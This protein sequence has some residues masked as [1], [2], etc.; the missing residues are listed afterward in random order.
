MGLDR[1]DARGLPRLSRALVDARRRERLA[2]GAAEHV[3]LPCRSCGARAAGRAA[4]RRPEPSA[5]RPRFSARS[6]R[7]RCDPSR[8]RRAIT[9]VA[10]STC[11]PLERLQLAEPEPGVQRRAVQA[12]GRAARARQVAG[13]RRRGLGCGCGRER[14]GPSARWPCSSGLRPGRRGRRRGCRSRAVA[15]SRIARSSARARARRAGRRGL[16]RRPCGRRRACA[17]RASGRTWSRSVRS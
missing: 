11:S 8:R 17:P 13:S 5:A 10:R 7:G 4:R 3:A 2:G 15:G 1:L 9:P 16:A 12:R 14:G 6:P